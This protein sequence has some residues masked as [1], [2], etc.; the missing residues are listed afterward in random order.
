MPNAQMP[1]QAAH[2]PTKDVPNVQ[3]VRPAILHREHLLSMQRSTKTR[4]GMRDKF[5]ARRRAAGCLRKPT[6][7]RKNTHTPQPIHTH[8]LSRSHKYTHSH[9][10]ARTRDDLTYHA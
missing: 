1:T 2:K 4:A 5:D 7:T 10:R 9:L 8:M 3:H 6:V